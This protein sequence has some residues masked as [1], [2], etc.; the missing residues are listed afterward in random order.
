MLKKNTLKDIFEV[1]I[2]KAFIL[3]LI[4]DV[5]ELF[6]AWCYFSAYSLYLHSLIACL[7]HRFHCYICTYLFFPPLCLP[8]VSVVIMYWAA[9]AVKRR[10]PPLC[11]AV[12]EHIICGA[13][14]ERRSSCRRCVLEFVEFSSKQHS[15]GDIGFSADD[16]EHIFKMRLRIQKHHI[17][18]FTLNGAKLQ[19]TCLSPIHR[20]P[21]GS[22]FLL[23]ELNTGT[24][25]NR[26]SH[27]NQSIFISS[28][29]FL[30]IVILCLCC[31]GCT[32][33]RFI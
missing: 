33:V 12:P 18:T 28:K 9:S 11:R 3:N 8:C 17:S 20:P 30:D 2:P 10:R 16:N 29:I 27:L 19:I 15:C 31:R 6:M 24:I 7:Y 1:I 23:P 25:R 14:P 26:T 22:T 4:S 21:P 5:S 13:K 32:G